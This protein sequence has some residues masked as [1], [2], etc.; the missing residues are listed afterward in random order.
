MSVLVLA[1]VDQGKLTAS[2]TRVVAAAAELG[3][4]LGA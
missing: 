4:R 2:T 1:D 3:T